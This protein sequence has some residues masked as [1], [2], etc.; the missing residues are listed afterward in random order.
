M[1]KYLDD[2]YGITVYQEQVMLLS[3][4]LAG[5]TKGEADSLRKAMGKKK[6]SIMDEMKLKFQE[7][8]KRNGHDESIANKIWSDWESFAQYAFNKSHS[9][10]Y[11]LI[12]YQTGFLKANYPAEY[13]AAVLSRNINDIKKITTFMD[14]TRRMGMDV[15]GPDANESNVK[16]T[17]NKDGNVRFGLGAIKGV[18][19]SAVLQ[20]IEE[21]EKNGLYKD[22]YDLVERVNLN[23]LNKKNLEAMAVA[24]AFDCFQG[25][26]RAQY[27]SLDTKGSSF[28]ESLI[29]Y[30]NNAK[31]VKTS[32]QQSLFGES[33]GFDM[34][35]PEPAPCPDWPK[36]EKLN[37]EKEVI[38]IYLSSHPLDDFKLEISTFATATLADLQNLRDYLERDVVVAGMV[39]DTRNGIGKNGKPYG[40]FTLQDY[41]DSFRFMMFDKDFIEFSK[42]FTLGYYLLIKGRVQ[43]RKYKEDELEFRIKTITLLSSVKDELIKTVTLKINPDN[44]NAEMINE[45]REL[46]HE[47]KG[48]T[49]LKFLFTDT[50]DKISLPMFSRSYRV[51]LNNELISYLED[52]PG[53]DFKVN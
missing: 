30:G 8:C 37:R 43:K 46:V 21:R 47:N 12:A 28:I 48:E 52:H 17:V 16:F 19:E 53:I 38:G 41:S 20:L 18:G 11:A 27:F 44:I 23:A 3:Q 7:G 14:E 22:I 24:G 36:L 40:S 51:R 10:C 50:D 34:I 33:G 45:L 26:I 5:F 35:R 15:L 13:M 31:M 9:T 29:R 32:S 39:T 1:E 6:R 4:E 42:Y 2:T 49:E 25:I